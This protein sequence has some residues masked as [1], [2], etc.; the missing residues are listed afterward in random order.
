MGDCCLVKLRGG[1]DLESSRLAL[2]RAL[3]IRIAAL[4]LRRRGSGQPGS[5]GTGS[6]WISD[7][8]RLHDLYIEH[9]NVFLWFLLVNPSVFDSVY[10]IQALNGPPKNSMFVIQPWL[11]KVSLNSKLNIGK[12]TVFSVVIKN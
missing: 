2:R 10:H 3:R 9:F 11:Q 4:C 1:D 8:L 12:L 6:R 7:I 5:N